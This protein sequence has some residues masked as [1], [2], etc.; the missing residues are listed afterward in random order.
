MQETLC[1]PLGLADTTITLSQEQQA[2]MALRYTEDGKHVP[3]WEFDVLAPAGA[4]RST[5]DDLLTFA[6]AN[7]TVTDSALSKAMHLARQQHFAHWLDGASGLGWMK[8][9]SPEDIDAWWHDGGTGA[10]SSFVGFSEKHQ[11]AVVVLSSYGNALYD[12]DALDKVGFELLK[13]ATKVS[14]R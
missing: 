14:L 9:V 11:V 10:Y 4:I 2:R 1:E 7:L 8:L 12:G 13:L 3:N 5:A 6:E